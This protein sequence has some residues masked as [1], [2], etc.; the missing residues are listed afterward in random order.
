M[1][2][3]V[4]TCSRT[5]HFRPLLA[6]NNGQKKFTTSV[7]KQLSFGDDNAEDYDGVRIEEKEDNKGEPSS[8]KTQILELS[9]L[10]QGIID[11]ESYV[12]L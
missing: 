9:E 5:N 7:I 3:Y 11:S 4:F 8:S 10:T 1:S 6:T 12:C 2:P